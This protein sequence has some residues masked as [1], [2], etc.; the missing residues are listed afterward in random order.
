MP[1]YELT[2]AADGDLLNIARYTI[3]T[4]GVEQAERYAAAMHEHFKTLARGAAHSRSFLEHWPE[5]LLS[6]CE[7]HYIFFVQRES[8]CP[9]ILAVFHENMDM[10]ARLRGRL[11]QRGE[12]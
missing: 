12:E 4:W 6:H 3:R 7:H 5:L 10:M 1:E 8:A 9:L 2:A 11:E